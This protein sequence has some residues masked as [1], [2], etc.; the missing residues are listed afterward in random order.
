MDLDLLDT[1]ELV[2]RV[3]NEDFAVA[4]AVKAGKCRTLLKLLT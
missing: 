2:T 3:Q 4:E 1:T